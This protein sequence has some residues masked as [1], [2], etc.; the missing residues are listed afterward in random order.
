MPIKVCSEAYFFRLEVLKRAPRTF[1]HDFYFL[2]NPSTSDEF[3]HANIGSRGEHVTQRPLRPTSKKETKGIL[4]RKGENRT[5]PNNILRRKK[6]SIVLVIFWNK[7][8]FFM[9]SLK[10]VKRI[11]RKNMAPSLYEKYKKI[12]GAKGGSWRSKKTETTVYQSNM[13]SISPWTC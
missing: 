2:K 11:G 6:K 10:E 13:S 5:F 4:E 8:A 1:S 12:L 3:E 9:M 7:I